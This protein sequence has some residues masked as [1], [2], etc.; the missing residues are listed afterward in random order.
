MT[1]DASLRDL[2]ERSGAILIG[3]RELRELQR[4]HAGPCVTL[5][6]T[7]LADL[8]ARARCPRSSSP[9]TSSTHVCF[10]PGD[11][12]IG[13]DDGAI[14]FTLQASTASTSRVARAR[15][16]A[17]RNGRVRV[18]ARS[19]VRAALDV[20]RARGARD[21]APRE[22]R[23]ALPLARRRPGQHPRRHAVRDARLRA[24]SRRHQ[25]GDPVGFRRDPPPASASNARPAPARVD[26]AARAYPHWVDELDRGHRARHRVRGARRATARRSGSAVTRATAAAGSARWRPIRTRSTAASAPP[27]SPRCAPISTRAATPTGEIAWVSNLRF[28]GKCGATVSRVFQGGHLALN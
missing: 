24:R 21:R 8:C 4:A 20:A 23:P 12:I 10:G 15:R 1:T 17:P 28:Y 7:A 5:T 6:P 11:E 19:S 18:S 27:S 13:D 2:V 22:R 26:F 25:H 9:S 16:R 14:A 3:Y